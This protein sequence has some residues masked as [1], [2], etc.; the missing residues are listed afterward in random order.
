M[1][2]ARVFRQTSTSGS[3]VDIFRAPYGSQMLKLLLEGGR[4]ILDCLTT[5]LQIC[6]QSDTARAFQL[7][8]IFAEDMLLEL[9]DSLGFRGQYVPRLN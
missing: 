5:Q 3:Q 9:I 6:F 7:Q 1:S 4:S 8:C 2:N